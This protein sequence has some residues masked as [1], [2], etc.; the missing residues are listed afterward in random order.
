MR[1]AAA[2]LSSLSP[3]KNV[4]R[5]LRVRDGLPA[6]GV[7]CTSAAA[8]KI[9]PA[10]VDPPAK[11]SPT[12]PR[13]SGSA[14]R[15]GDG[16]GCLV[17]VT[18]GVERREADI[19]SGVGGVVLADGGPSAISDVRAQR[20]VATGLGARESRRHT[21]VHRLP[22]TRRAGRIDPCG[23]AGARGGRRCWLVPPA[24]DGRRH[25]AC[26]EA[27]GAP[28]AAGRWQRGCSHCP[29]A[30][31]DRPRGRRRRRRSTAGREGGPGQGACRGVALQPGEIDAVDEAHVDEQ[32]PVDLAV[33][34]DRND[35]LFP[36]PGR[37]ASLPAEPGRQPDQ[38][39]GRNRSPRGRVG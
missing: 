35:V 14:T 6:D 2:A 10:V 17:G 21:A 3:R 8:S 15:A 31:H 12:T 13:T 29:A 9:A 16:G 1:Q 26:D 37:Q 4:F 33:V 19:T 24:G 38:S 34:V 30:A 11:G 7:M 25:D 20:R 5:P 18:R 23:S 27:D 22:G 32:L 39:N 36:Q 28:R